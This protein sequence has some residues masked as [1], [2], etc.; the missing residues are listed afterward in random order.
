MNKLLL[1]LSLAL[2][3]R[4][5]SLHDLPPPRTTAQDAADDLPPPR[6]DEAQAAHSGRRGSPPLKAIAQ[7]TATGDL[8]A[9]TPRS[10][11]G[12][13]PRFPALA[14]VRGRRPVAG[15]W[16]PARRATEADTYST[17]RASACVLWQPS[18][19]WSSAPAPGSTA[20]RRTADWPITMKCWAT[21]PTPIALPQRRHPPDA[22]RADLVIWGRAD[23]IPLADRVSRV[24]PHPLFA[25]RPARPAPARSWR[26][27][28]SQTMGDYKLDTVWLPTVPWRAIA[29]RQRCMEPDQSG[30]PGEI[31]GIAPT[32]AVA[33]LV[34]AAQIGEDEHGSGG[35]ASTPDQD[36]RALRLRPDVRAHP[37]VESVL[38]GAAA[39]RSRRRSPRC[40]RSTPS[41]AR[42]MELEHNGL[43]LAH[44]A[45]LHRRR[46]GYPAD[47]R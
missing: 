20:C 36:R 15:S 24:R 10:G 16:R 31:I 23:E 32:P 21:T 42:D 38:P 19:N 33:A 27:A 5:P 22:G 45:R 14:Q 25:R 9:P 40:T 12:G 41:S 44:G 26:R 37:P 43:T 30:P 6:H 35:G 13:Q 39:H 28:G 29:R 3:T 34:G 11:K 8:P 18:R 1:T 7:L 46:T 2:A 17:L 4:P 47:A